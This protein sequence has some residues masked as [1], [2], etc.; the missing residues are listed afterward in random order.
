MTGFTGNG[1]QCA[2]INECDTDNGGCSE[3]PKVECT[4]RVGYHECGPCPAGKAKQGFTSLLDYGGPWDPRSE[5]LGVPTANLGVI[6]K[7]KKLM[8]DK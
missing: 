7:I 3:S 5:N 8:S 4:N 1:F 6:H 2:D